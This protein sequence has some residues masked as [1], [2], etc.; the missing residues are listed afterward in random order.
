M[1]ARRA[2]RGPLLTV[3]TSLR[4]IMLALSWRSVTI[5]DM[6]RCHVTA[7]PGHRGSNPRS[8]I[9]HRAQPPSCYGTLVK[10]EEGDR[11]EE[12]PGSNPCGRGG[13]KDALYRW[14]LARGSFLNARGRTASADLSFLFGSQWEALS[15][16]HA[17]KQQVAL[18]GSPQREYCRLVE[19]LK[20]TSYCM[21]LVEEGWDNLVWLQVLLIVLQ[22][23]CPHR[24]AW[25]TACNPPDS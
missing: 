11:K 8:S 16:M 2:P 23:S 1:G 14:E 24:Q 20:R 15:L 10:R 13:D 9:E 25:A 12:V 22:L 18:S 4:R 21:P 17:A 19:N 3:L 6:T 7:V 5:F